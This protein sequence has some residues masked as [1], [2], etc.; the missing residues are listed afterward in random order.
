MHSHGSRPKVLMF[1]WHGVHYPHH[2]QHDGQMSPSVSPPALRGASRLKTLAKGAMLLGPE[3]IV[4]Y[5]RGCLADG[6]GLVGVTCHPQT[7]S[8]LTV[9]T[10]QR[11]ISTICIHTISLQLSTTGFLGLQRTTIP[12]SRPSNE[13]AQKLTERDAWCMVS[14]NKELST[15]AAHR[16]ISIAKNQQ[17]ERSSCQGSEV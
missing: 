5:G 17:H 16:F 10:T 4:A 14:T 8:S 12:D 15:T 3:K 2:W 7:W 13:A 1:L 11:T 6:P 9:F